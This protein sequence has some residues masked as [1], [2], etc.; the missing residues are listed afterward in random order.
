MESINATIIEYIKSAAFHIIEEE[1]KN[2][3][4]SHGLL[5]IANNDLTSIITDYYNN[6]SKSIKSQIRESLKEK[7]K[8]Q[9]NSALIENI[10]LD[11]FQ[12][13]DL[14]IL[15][16]IKE[17]EFLQE[18]NLKQ[19][20]IPII[21]NSLNL[22]IS[23]VDN[24]IIINSTNPKNIEEH[25][26]LYDSIKNYKFLYSINNILLHNYLDNEKINVIKENIASKTEITIECY[27]LQSK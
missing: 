10:L 27:Y 14:N 12:E 21:N 7:Y 15:K 26:E 23:L 5:L 9:Y 8:D 4:K 2:Y 22:N 25:E 6:N 20:I 24:Y 3:L 1:Y 16:I 11:L 17:L 18:N 13:K 19:F